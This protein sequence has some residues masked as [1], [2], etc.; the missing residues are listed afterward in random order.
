MIFS[1]ITE[2]TAQLLRS[3][4]PEELVGGSDLKFLDNEREPNELLHFTDLES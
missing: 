1:S 4:S 3:P 2:K